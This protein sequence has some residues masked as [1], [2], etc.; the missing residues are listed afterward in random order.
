MNVHVH[1]HEHGGKA[2]APT[3]DREQDHLVLQHAVRQVTGAIASD[4][5]SR[6][7]EHKRA[8]AIRAIASECMVVVRA[9]CMREPASNMSH[10][11]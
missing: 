5:H 3:E 1:E 9:V 8:L 4:E 2:W 11:M 6:T 10:T 7:K